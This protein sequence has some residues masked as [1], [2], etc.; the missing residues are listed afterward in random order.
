MSHSSGEVVLSGPSDRER[1]QPSSAICRPAG[2]S[3]EHFIM[4]PTLGER[5]GGHPQQRLASVISKREGQDVEGLSV[6][7]V[8]HQPSNCF[9]FRLFFF[10]ILYRLI[11]CLFLGEVCVQK[12]N[13][14]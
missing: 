2:P 8:K 12:L 7:H 14:A 5:M 4:S 11:G 6:Y 1:Y 3:P 13:P 10:F 9:W